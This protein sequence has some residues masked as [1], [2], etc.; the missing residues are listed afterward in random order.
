M[1]ETKEITTGAKALLKELKRQ[2]VKRF[3]GYPGGVLLG[4]YDELYGEQDLLHILVRHEQGGCHAA[5][6][7]A[8]VAG[9]PGLVL[10]TS[11]PGATNLVTGIADAYM[12]STPIVC[13]T[14]QVPTFGIGSDFFQEADITGI[15]YPI[16]KHSYLI[17]E[18][19]K[20]ATAVANA[21]H[22]AG[23]GRPGPVLIDMPKDVLNG[24]YEVDANNRVDDNFKADI[25]GYKPRTKG[26]PR[27]ISNA[28]K[29]ILE[30]RR[31]VIYAGGG[32]INSGA[33]KL[34]QELGESCNIPVT[35]TLQGKGA[36]PHKHPL[37]LGMLGMHGTAYA[38]FSIY[39]CD[40]LIAV[41]VR[42]D[43]RVTGKIAEFAPDADVIH[44]D[45]DPAEVGKNRKMR[46]EID[47]PIVGDA[48]LVLEELIAKIEEQK[49]DTEEWLN[50]VQEWKDEYPLDYDPIAEELISPQH[51]LK[52]IAK[53]GGDKVVYSTD[54]GQH[55]MWS[56]QYAEIN[57][58][59]KWLT[60]G[61]AGTMGFG[62]P[63]AMG[64]AAALKDSEGSDNDRS[65]E[66]AVN[67]SGDGSFQMCEQEL[68]T[69]KAYD[70]KVITCIFNNQNL[71]MVRQWQDLF[72]DKHYSHVDLKHGSPDFVKLADAYGLKGYKPQTRAELEEVMAKAFEDP[73]ATVIDV[74]MAYEMN[75]WPIVPPGASNM[76]MMGI[77]SCTL[78]SKQRE[79]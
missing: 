72:Y 40:L 57:G 46:S 48:R 69:L 70:L 71:G 42:F 59:R 60:S 41:G 32:V 36:M 45:I 77:D 56:A 8:R 54:V 38:N 21:F 76:D 25:R 34:L 58:P 55:Q 17:K 50:K 79:Q 52:S 18:P 2:G 44:I 51:V 23:S 14:G 43:D 61:G 67:I 10:A 11:G 35:T 37:F 39:N 47:I 20:L 29:K 4:L 26:N 78:T 3:F 49:P 64:A 16:V 53:L 13:L 33:S 63:A 12:D 68:G 5:E 7:Y 31:P 75:V 65:D 22:I 9:R 62:L 27:Q 6:G 66:V 1:P 24:E 73:E 30:A 28:A 74:P 15:T 19:K